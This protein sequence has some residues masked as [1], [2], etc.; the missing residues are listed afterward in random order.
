MSDPAGRGQHLRRALE[1]YG[2]VL[3]LA[4][5]VVVF[6]LTSDAFLRTANLLNI[7]KQISFLTIL[8]VG[9]TLALAA[10]ELDLSFANVCSLASV[11]VGGLLTVG[12]P[13]AGAVAV[14]LAI[15]AAF[16]LANG[17]LVT[18]L[19]VPSLIATLATASIANGIAFAITGGVAYVGRLAEPFLALARA[20]VLG[21]PVLVLWTAGVVTLAQVFVA[22]TRP[23]LHLVMTGEAE[24]AARLAG[25]RTRSMKVL[26]LA[27]SGLAAGLTAVLL[28]ASLSSAG[29]TIAYDFLMRGIAAVLLGM[30]T[31]EPGRPNVP[32]TLVGALMIGV[33]TNGLTL[34]GAPY[35]VQDVM[36]GVIILG[37]VGLS[38]S[39]LKRAAFGLGH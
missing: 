34:A 2:T 36:L 1:L 33:L 15:G 11:A 30:T 38:A 19:K 8:G 16:G 13:I 14:G 25:I 6:A 17:V 18:R 39:Q 35:Y 29:P 27:L 4:V 20:S 21:M 3:A 37:S 23:G 31:I 12:W 28:T 10:A 22:T 32:G 9:F 24:A 26:A 7:A 5:L